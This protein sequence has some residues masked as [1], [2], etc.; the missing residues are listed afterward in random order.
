MQRLLI[1]QGDWPISKRFYAKGQFYDRFCARKLVFM[2]TAEI[3]NDFPHAESL[4]QFE[5]L[6]PA[7]SRPD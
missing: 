3:S 6:N 5:A 1:L 7:V 2:Q 4:E